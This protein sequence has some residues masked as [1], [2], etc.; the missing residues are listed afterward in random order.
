MSGC[1][2][3]FGRRLS[4]LLQW[5]VPGMWLDNGLTSESPTRALQGLFM[6]VEGVDAETALLAE[7]NVIHV[8]PF[9]SRKRF[10]R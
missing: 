6:G 4:T 5:F 1:G 3:S 9:V 7:Q 10:E 2:E 8:L